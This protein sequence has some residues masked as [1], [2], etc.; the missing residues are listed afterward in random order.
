MLC[1]STDEHAASQGGLPALLHV[2]Q[3]MCSAAVSLCVPDVVEGLTSVVRCD[4]VKHVAAC[5]CHRHS[6]CSSANTLM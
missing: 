3:G 6:C 4:I 2:L 1:R 5:C